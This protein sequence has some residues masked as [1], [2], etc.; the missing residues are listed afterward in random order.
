[1]KKIFLV[2]CFLIIGISAYTQT[3]PNLISGAIKAKIEYQLPFQHTVI[4]LEY[5]GLILAYKSKNKDFNG[6]EEFL[7]KKYDF[8]L[9]EEYELKVGGL[10]KSSLIIEYKLEKDL[11]YILFKNKENFSVVKINLVD[12]KSLVYN[13]YENE[14]IKVKHLLVNK[15]VVSVAGITMNN[16]K[17]RNLYFWLSAPV[18]FIPMIFYS[19]KYIPIVINIDM[20]NEEILQNKI[21]I[22]NYLHKFI[23]V[24]DFNYSNEDSTSEV[25]LLIEY[26]EKNNKSIGLYT[27]GGSKK[28]DIRIKKKGSNFFYS[29][30][31]CTID[32]SE[33]ILFGIY[34]SDNNIRYNTEGFYIYSFKNGKLKYNKLIEWKDLSYTSING[35]K[36]FSF[37]ETFYNF[38]FNLKQVVLNDNEIIFAGEILRGNRVD[39]V[40]IFAIDDNG[41]LLWNNGFNLDGPAT[42]EEKIRTNILET[43]DYEFTAVTNE[44][45]K[46][47]VKVFDKENNSLTNDEIL[48]TNGKP[49]REET[50]AYL[51]DCKSN[52]I[53]WYDNVYLA[54]GTTTTKG[55]YINKIEILPR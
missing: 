54:I 55:Y 39:G 31:F 51:Y 49:L 8:N 13:N 4:P 21:E 42:D 5:Y 24:I 50:S 26:Y 48:I 6:K 16:K 11:L 44:G 40:L 9:K 46:V 12:K 23:D 10:P 7:F 38:Y 22:K 14:G 30:Y 25:N 1:M 15:G 19:S 29:N 53:N 20:N 18:V 27:M 45:S 35:G 47:I 33:K 28:S 3:Q 41:K 32:N 34:T 43:N 2:F 17:R 37:S 52:I 36:N